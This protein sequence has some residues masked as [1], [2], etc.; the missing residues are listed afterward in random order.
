MSLISA[1]LSHLAL[2]LA[3]GQTTSK[4]VWDT[5]MANSKQTEEEVDQPIIEAEEEDPIEVVIIIKSE[6]LSRWLSSKSLSL[7]LSLSL[8]QFLF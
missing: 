4:G 8:P 2:A 6:F 7:S 3:V 5:L 1:T